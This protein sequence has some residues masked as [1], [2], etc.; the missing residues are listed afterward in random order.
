VGRCEKGGGEG[1]VKE[2][3]GKWIRRGR[4]GKDSKRT[5]GGKGSEGMR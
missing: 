5:V 3:A 4:Q 1:E 2:K